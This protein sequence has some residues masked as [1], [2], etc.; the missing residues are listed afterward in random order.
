MIWSNRE[1]QAAEFEPLKNAA[2]RISSSISCKKM[3]FLARE[4][5]FLI[6]SPIQNCKSEP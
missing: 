2:S 6:L 1:E 5:D 3:P 4:P